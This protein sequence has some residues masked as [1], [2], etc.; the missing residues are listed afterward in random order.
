MNKSKVDKLLL[1]ISPEQR[2]KFTSKTGQYLL[3]EY[4]IEVGNF[5]L[6]EILAFFAQEV[7]ALFYNQGVL[8]DIAQGGIYM[9]EKNARV[10]GTEIVWIDEF[11]G[12]TGFVANTPDMP[13]T[14]AGL[15]DR[16]CP[17]RRWCD[18]WKG[19]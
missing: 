8:V 13:T 11:P 9:L 1:T 3:N 4:D 18:H 2:D 12:A 6:E 17:C 19:R 14:K 7:G 10:K 5:D 15:F 16:S